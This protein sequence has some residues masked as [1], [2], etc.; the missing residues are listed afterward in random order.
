MEYRRQFLGE[1]AEILIESDGR[2]GPIRQSAGTGLTVCG[3]SERYFKAY[4]SKTQSDKL[5][6][7]DIVKIRLI[8][9]YKDGLLGVVDGR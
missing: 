1:T 6:N 7:N 2:T 8:E 3:R 4:L 5:K 9:N